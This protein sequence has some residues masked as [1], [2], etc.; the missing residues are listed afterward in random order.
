MKNTQKGFV[1]A[2]LVLIIIILVAVVAY[3][4]GK[5][6]TSTPATTSITPEVTTTPVATATPT[7]ITS[8]QMYSDATLSFEYPRVLTVFKKGDTVV[9]THEIPYVHA[10]PCDFRGDAQQASTLMDFNTSLTIVNQGIQAYVKSTNGDWTY[11]S[12]NP[13]TLGGWKGYKNDAGVEGCGVVTYYLTISPAKTLVITRPYSDELNPISAD[14]QKN[15]SLPAV[16]P[17]AQAE[18]Y[19]SQILASLKLK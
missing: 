1:K 11:I 4:I 16:I 15:L 3:F 13:V 8:T 17:P 12:K 10:A 6:G 7:P 9:M 2:L 5:S 14:Y 19:F 18:T